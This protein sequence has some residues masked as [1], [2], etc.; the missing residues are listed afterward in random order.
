M[1]PAADGTADPTY[2]R[3]SRRILPT[4]T[5]ESVAFW[6]GGV[7]GQLMIQYCH[8]CGRYFHP[9]APLCWRCRSADVAP[10]AASGRGSVAAYTVNRQ[11]WIPGFEPP[12]IIA[13]VELEDEPDVRLT[14]NLIDV[15]EA[16]VS[17]GL[18]VQV[19]FEKWTAEDGTAVWLP[20]F[21]PV[22]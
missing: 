12:Y 2:R 8:A 21:R 20:L 7:H 6:S 4:P 5:A 18:A 1:N 19:A 17:T 9:P 13:I 3:P 22:R 11:P 10:K 15:A 16:D 14:T